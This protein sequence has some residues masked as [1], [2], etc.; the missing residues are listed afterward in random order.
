M[1]RHMAQTRGVQTLIHSVFPP[2]CLSCCANVANDDGLCGMSWRD[3]AFI[4]G[5][6][7]DGCGVPL[8]GVCKV[9]IAVII[10]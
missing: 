9:G 1:S 7:C 6:I 3:T 5:D 2:E 8:R 10:A 4:A